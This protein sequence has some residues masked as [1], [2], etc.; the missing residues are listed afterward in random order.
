MTVGVTDPNGLLIVKSQSPS[1]GEAVGAVAQDDSATSSVRS[2]I[3]GVKLLF[4]GYLR[5]ELL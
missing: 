1:T 4:M 5:G 3:A 2:R